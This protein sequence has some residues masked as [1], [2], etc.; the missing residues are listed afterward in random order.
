MQ[1]MHDRKNIGKIILDPSLEPKPAAEVILRCIYELIY[2][3]I[4]LMYTLLCYKQHLQNFRAI[5]SRSDCHEL[6]DVCIN[7]KH[8]VAFSATTI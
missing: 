3:Y 7:C 4:Y 5:I 8:T 1:R 2:Y 6:R